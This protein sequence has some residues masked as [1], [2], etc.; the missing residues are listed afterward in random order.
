MNVKI[1]NKKKLA[2][3]LVAATITLSTQTGCIF[4][5]EV[6]VMPDVTEQ[7]NTIDS[8]S[9]E[10]AFEP[11][12]IDVPGEDFKLVIEYTL[13]GDASK[14]WRITSDKKI[15][16]KVYTK[17]LPEGKKVYIDNVHTDITIISTYPEMNG[18]TQD[19]MDDRIHNSLMYGFPISDTTCFY[20]INE[21]EGQNDTFISGSSI[22]FNGYVSGSIDERRHTESEYLEKGVY[23][24][25]ITSI[26]GLL[27]QNGD[28]EPYGVDVSADVIVLANNKITKETE[29]GKQK[30]YVYDRKGNKTEYTNSNN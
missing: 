26:Y 30:V 24:N 7:Y 6:A 23:A 29:D 25:K 16:T 28:D 15:Y 12:I 20:A 1:G 19:S 27:I 3:V 18:I 21:I 2:A 14:E 11:Q 9:P 4:E 22:G 13:E 10:E 5:N 8:T 17:G